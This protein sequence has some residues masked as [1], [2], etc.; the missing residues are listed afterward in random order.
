MYESSNPISQ[1]TLNDKEREKIAKALDDW[2]DK[3]NASPR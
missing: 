2:K 3:G 1:W